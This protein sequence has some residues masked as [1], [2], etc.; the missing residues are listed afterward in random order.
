MAGSFLSAVR[1]RAAGLARALAPIGW[2]ITARKPDP[3]RLSQ[4]GGEA[5]AAFVLPM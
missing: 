3:Q 5:I 1:G 4:A 2:P